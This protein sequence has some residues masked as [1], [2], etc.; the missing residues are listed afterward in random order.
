[1]AVDLKSRYCD[2]VKSFITL[3]ELRNP[4][5]IDHC[6]IVARYCSKVAEQAGFSQTQRDRVVLAA[7]VHTMGVALQME[8]KKPDQ[9]LPIT[10]LGLECDRELPSHERERKILEKVLTG[11]EEL[12]ECI[13]VISQ[14]YEWFDGSASLF[15]LK[16]EEILEE[17]RLLAVVDAF[18]DLATP[19]KHR[20]QESTQECLRRILEVSGTQ[21]DPRFVEALTQVLKEEDG[22][23]KDAGRVAHFETARCR[24]YL[25]LG[26]LYTAIHETRWALRSYLKAENIA[27]AMGDSGLE[28][29]AISGQ[30]LVLCNQGSLELAREALQRARTRSKSD[31]EKR[32]YHLMWGLLEWLTGRPQNGKDILE[33]LIG[34][35]REHRNVP[36]LTTALALQAHCMLLFQGPEDK[37]FL[38][39]LTEFCDLC[40]R[41][42]LF[43]IVE[44]YRPFTLPLFLAALL[45]GVGDTIARSNLTR[46]GEPCH[47]ALKAKLAKAEPKDWNKTLQPEPVIPGGEVTPAPVTEGKTDSDTIQIQT[48]GAFRLRIGEKEVMED[49]WPTQKSLRIFAHL[50]TT[51]GTPLADSYL[52]E[53]FW[54]SSTQDKARNSLRNAIHQI[55][56][57]LKEIVETP[58]SQVL[59]RSRKAGTVHFQYAYEVDCDRFESL[60]KTAQEQLNAES[61]Q[62]A[63]ETVREAMS[64]YQGDFLDGVYEDWADGRRVQLKE[65]HMRSL[66]ILGMAYLK[67]GNSEAAEVAARKLLS[68]DDLRE[69]GHAILIEAVNADGRP[70]EAIRLY[71]EAEELFEREIGVSP[72]GLR[73][74][75]ERVGLLLA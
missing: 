52:M 15:G 73:E 8:E 68:L 26:H 75:L 70:A 45:N 1:M 10:N 53:T 61:Y 69:D 66:T 31:R 34:H 24:H 16:G 72:A 25:N 55:R 32:G 39:V 12:E 41:H 48:L 58:A 60:L 11:V 63:L 23:F 30:V 22:R 47:P 74:V 46:M 27:V 67:L 29:G 6:K 4:Y 5:N 3:L 42:D 51:G 59:V 43:D 21:F 49:D 65:S 50:V 38:E 9:N 71:E 13:D 40:H 33:K 28:L 17:A 64:L 37:E 18:V 35:H 62:Q 56:S 57:V 20:P 54:P 7:E 36:G 19:K 44:R 14:R 2:L